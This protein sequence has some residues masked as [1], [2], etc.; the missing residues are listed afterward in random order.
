MAATNDNVIGSNSGVFA[1]KSIGGA[2]AAG[3]VGMIVTFGVCA[4]RARA[5]NVLPNGGLED[6]AGPLGWNLSVS[7]PTSALGDYN[8]N[9]SVDAADYVLWRNGGPLQ[10]EVNT[11]GT[12]D[13]SDYTAWRARF[14]NNTAGSG[15]GS[16]EDRAVP[17]PSTSLLA[18]LAIATTA[19][20][21]RIKRRLARNP[22][23]RP[24]PRG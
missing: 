5:A 21:S 1:M 4:E 3:A 9:G 15:S 2:L 11:S 20:V 17:E 23:S 12:V 19:E 22:G 18:L 8:G 14:G 24:A 7:T 16:L 10:N 6:S 13:A